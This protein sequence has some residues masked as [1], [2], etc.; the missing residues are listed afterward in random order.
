[1]GMRT[2]GLA[3]LL[4]ALLAGCGDDGPAT[5]GT[6]GT[7]PAVAC[8]AARADGVPVVKADLDGDGTAET[9][10][11]LPPTA[12]CGAQLAATVAGQRSVT[13]LDEEIPVRPDESF[14]I[15]VP[16]R[17]G[18]I[19]V[20]MQVHPRGGFQVQLLGWS[21][22]GLS[23]FNVDDAPV[24]PFVATDTDPTPFGARCVPRG[25]EID[26]AVRHE[27]VGVVPAWDIRRTRYTFNGTSTTAGPTQEI[28][29]NVLEKQL[30]TE[31]RDLVRHEL[32]TDCRADS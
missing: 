14:A 21:T 12:S 3:V 13:A 8:P 16:G 10:E 11:Y 9:V 28:A 23:T 32:F 2:L 25:I 31:H 1:M 30:R 17:S 7:A 20:V 18:Q 24:F 19:A 5:G 26:Q 4:P 22:A 27:P 6:T 29:D 15:A